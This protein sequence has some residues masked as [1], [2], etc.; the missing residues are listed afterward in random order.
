MK[1]FRDNRGKGHQLPFIITSTILAIL[2]GRN[3][4]SSIHRFIV[5]K[6][7]WLKEILDRPE[8]YALSRAQ[9]PRILAVVKWEELNKPIE[10]FFGINIQ[11][12]DGEWTA[13]DGKTLCGT[14]TDKKNKAQLRRR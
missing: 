5:N 8:A 13:V 3:N 14:I 7:E 10:E 11:L 4:M 6:I 12:I 1:D 9:L 2:S